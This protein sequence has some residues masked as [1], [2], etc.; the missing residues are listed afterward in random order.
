MSTVLDRTQQQE[1]TTEQ[2]GAMTPEEFV[3]QLRDE[4]RKPG[5]GMYDH[6]F[7]RAVENGT[8]TLP[9][10]RAVAEQFYLHIRNMLPAIGMMYVKCP[11]EDVRA[12][13]VKNLAEECLGVFSKTKAHPDLM[14]DFCQAIGIDTD[15]LR[16]A[17]QN[18]VGRNLTEY[19]ELVGFQRPWFVNLAAIGIGLESFVPETFTRLV[20]GLK[21]NYGLTD[22]QVKFWSM[23]ILADAEHGDEGI[24][25]VEHWVHSGQERKLVMDCTIEMAER[26]YQLWSLYQTAN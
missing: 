1:L 16:K 11:Y 7:V 26:F 9:Q 5:R 25:I 3:N 15:A 6:P 21:D 8:A 10:I 12:T 18:K 17:E 14:L 4:L 22:E 13:L 24:E 2:L 23:H 20:K 19:F